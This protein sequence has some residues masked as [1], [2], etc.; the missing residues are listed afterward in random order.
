MSVVF[1]VFDTSYL[2]ELANCG[3][4]ADAKASPHVRKLAK[5]AAA[6]GARFVVP[7]PCLFELGDHIAD[8]KHAER[9]QQLADW[10]A[11]TVEESLAT[12]RPW[13]ITPTGNPKDILPELLQI[14]RGQGV[15]KQIGLVDLFAAS[16]A[17]RLKT[18]Y[19]DRKAKVH[20]WTNDR[21]LKGQEPDHE[22]NPFHW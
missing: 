11:N 17:H 16:E 9:R 2:I 7:L 18:D 1:Y 22:P 21:A 14:F 13:I 4:D 6:A 10:L 19:R 12:E 5:Q 15:K 20:I 3:R 8:V